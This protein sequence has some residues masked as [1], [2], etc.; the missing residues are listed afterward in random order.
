LGKLRFHVLFENVQM[1]EAT[2]EDFA[3]ACCNQ[4]TKLVGTFELK[5]SIKNEDI[6]V[7]F[8]SNFVSGYFTEG[9]AQN[10][11][12][13]GYKNSSSFDLLQPA[14]SNLIMA[15]SVP[16]LAQLFPG[17]PSL[18][19]SSLLY[20][21]S[22]IFHLTELATSLELRNPFSENITVK[23][24]NLLLYP[25]KNQVKVAGIQICHEY[26]ASPL[27]RFAPSNFESIFIPAN[28]I[29]GCFSCCQGSKCQEK[30]KLCP[31]AAT[32]HC[33]KASIE[34][35]LSPE[36]IVAL[37]HTATSGLLMKVNGTINAYIG[38]YETHLFYQQEGLLVTLASFFS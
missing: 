8:L 29:S 3:L 28:T 26:Y 14:L 25:C 32:G 27:A 12:I 38:T 37:F 31:R 20:R 2:I 7:R 22:S 17:T 4:T 5:P 16:T 15:S 13:K 24:V 30:I 6:V 10:I 36:A 34:S 35:F 19:T 23:S 1:G 33:M 11:T 18:V 21:P 9:H